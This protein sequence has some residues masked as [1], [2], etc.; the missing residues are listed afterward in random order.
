MH[1]DLT[2][3][4]RTADLRRGGLLADAAR[5]RLADRSPEAPPT[6]GARPIALRAAAGR[7]LVRAG[8]RL[9]GL[10]APLGVAP[11]LAGE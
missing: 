2:C 9:Q 4:D 5:A 8:E 6:P 11:A 3:A 7:A 10:P 1:P